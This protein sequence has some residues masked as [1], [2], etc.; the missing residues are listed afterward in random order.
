MRHRRSPVQTEYEK[1][2]WYRFDE[3]GSG[4]AEI[5]RRSARIRKLQRQLKRAVDERAWHLYL[6]L[7][8]EVNDRDALLLELLK[9]Q[10]RAE[11]RKAKRQA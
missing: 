8:S 7:E 2:F 9:E 11:A 1:H 10:F 4:H 3:V 5:K 6:T